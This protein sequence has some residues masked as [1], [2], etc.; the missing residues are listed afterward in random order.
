MSRLHVPSARSL[1]WL[2]CLACTYVLAGTWAITPELARESLPRD[3]A[4]TAVPPKHA[5]TTRT[6]GSA[7]LGRASRQ[8][9]TGHYAPWAD[10]P[11]L[12]GPAAG[13]RVPDAAASGPRAERLPA[14]RRLPGNRAPYDATPPPAL[15]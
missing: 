9:A 15:R 3:V 5:A 7:A 14:G 4:V 8:A 13:W 2:L 10:V 6:P 11:A 12:L 1:V